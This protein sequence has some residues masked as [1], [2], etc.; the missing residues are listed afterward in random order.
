MSESYYGIE[1]PDT[2]EKWNRCMEASRPFDKDGEV[3]TLSAIIS[4]TDFGK[5]LAGRM[6]KIWKICALMSSSDSAYTSKNGEYEKLLAK[7]L[8]EI[9]DSQKAFLDYIFES[10]EHLDEFIR[11]ID[12]MMKPSN[13]E[14]RKKYWKPVIDKLK[15]MP[16][17]VAKQMIGSTKMLFPIIYGIDYANCT[18]VAKDADETIDVDKDYEELEKHEGNREYMQSIKI[19]VRERNFENSRQGVYPRTTY[20]QPR[21]LLETIRRKALDTALASRKKL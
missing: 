6:S 10:D 18:V 21:E 7:E 5:R 3:V 8:I 9:A 15:E 12:E 19:Q 14:P 17:D 20:R 1:V 2:I 11:T 16:K 4:E 13:P